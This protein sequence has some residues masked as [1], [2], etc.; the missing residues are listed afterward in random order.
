MDQMS[1]LR[2]AGQLYCSLMEEVL[3]RDEMI[4]RV[5]HDGLPQTPFQQTVPEAEVA[6]RVEFAYLQLRLICEL[7][8]L[9]CLAVH[10]DVPGARTKAVRKEYAADD[11]IKLL[12]RLHPDFYPKPSI[13]GEPLFGGLV[14]PTP[15]L[16]GYLTKEELIALYGECGRVLHRG[17]IKDLPGRNP[18]LPS[19]ETAR[20]WADK[21]W[22]LLQHHQ[23]QTWDR[24]ITIYAL[25]KDR[26]ESRPQFGLCQNR[27]GQWGIVLEVLRSTRSAPP[28]NPAQPQPGGGPSDSLAG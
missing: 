2:E 28:P 5:L 23:I 14:L 7:I 18:P 11:I 4:L 1:R 20:S 10:G 24:G 13:K 22:V 19:V 9:A 15:I 16:D 25:M 26:Q 8:A 12:A 27:P 21:I 17:T 3:A 6:M